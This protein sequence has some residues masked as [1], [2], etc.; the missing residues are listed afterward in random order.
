MADERVQLC[1][2]LR[3]AI[4]FTLPPSHPTLQTPPPSSSP[5]S[6]FGPTT[7][8]TMSA[9]RSISRAF[10]PLT[11]Q[12]SSK[13]ST[14]TSTQQLLSSSNRR[15]AA[16]AAAPSSH[17]A[18]LRRL[19]SPPSVA[20]ASSSSD[21]AASISS[22]SYVHDP[23]PHVHLPR[24]ARTEPELYAAVRPPP[25]SAFA[26]LTARLGLISNN[27]D[28][29]TRDR[30]DQVGVP[31]VYAS[32]VQALVDRANTQLDVSGLEKKEGASPLDAAQYIA[33]GAKEGC[34]A[35]RGIGDG[36]N[37][38]V[39]YVGDRVLHLRYPKLPTRVLKAAVSAYVGPTTLSDVGASSVM[40][41]QVSCDGTKTARVPTG[42]NLN[43]KRGNSRGKEVRTFV[44]KGR[45][46]RIHA[47]P[48]C[49]HLPRT[50]TF[51]NT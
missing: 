8:R 39:G 4:V 21:V 24:L 1:H 23:T 42:S 2:T 6:S 26:A 51:G 18:Q 22:S 41:G 9:N 40:S 5:F 33:T 45:S 25:L 19:L 30:Q 20:T 37:S 38:F 50:R 48:H 44:L 43:A 11:A 17:L 16:A 15:L 35:Q 36:G 46:F 31:G 28:A 49:R 34:R 27:V 13:A 14:S 29:E 32:F 47:C 7:I 10:R 12:S 3:L